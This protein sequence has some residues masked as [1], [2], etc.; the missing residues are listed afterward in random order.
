MRKAK[1]LFALT[2]LGLGAMLTASF[3]IQGYNI[4]DRVADFN[5]KNIDGKMISL[6]SNPNAKG[7]MVIFTCNHC[8]YAIA[9]EDRIIALH[10]K[11]APK[12]YP[13]LAINP[14]DVKKEPSDSF[15]KM[16]ERAKEKG[17]PFPYLIDETQEVAKAFGATRTPH[18]FLLQKKGDDFVVAYIGAIDDSAKDP[19]KVKEKYLENAV[20][21][22]LKGKNV[23]VSTTKAVGCT[24]KWKDA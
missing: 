17:F 4:G 15:E 6:K 1:V 8:P 2:L 21:A 12:G 14:N 7:Y 23:P 24:I 13:V 18:V 19:S 3:H 16:Q 5:L 22:L 9:Y 20:E 11:Y 10:N